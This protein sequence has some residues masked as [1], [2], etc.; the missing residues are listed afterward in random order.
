METNQTEP[1]EI[2]KALPQLQITPESVAYLAT[3]AKWTKF[4]SILGFVFSGFLLTAGFVLSVFFGSVSSQLEN[5]G[6]LPFFN[7]SFI[8]IIYLV[9]ALIYIWPIIY[10]NNF[11][12]FAT[13]A[14]QTG[15]TEKLT[16]ALLSLK[17]L[18]KFMGILMIIMLVIYL[19]AVVALVVAGSMLM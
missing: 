7:K 10:L 5:T 9:I 13:R 6:K 14:V 12:N 3:T 4:L 19:I 17:R 18:F 2:S 8:G 15:N 1:N 16:S 11:S